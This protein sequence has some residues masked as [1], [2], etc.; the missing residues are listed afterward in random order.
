MARIS[1][2]IDDHCLPTM[3][4]F[5]TYLAELET[6]PARGLSVFQVSS[7]EVQQML[8]ACAQSGIELQHVQASQLALVAGIDG[9]KQLFLIEQDLP[10][11]Q[12]E[13]IAT[14]LIEQIIYPLWF[15]HR[16]ICF[17]SH[18]PQSEYQD[19]QFSPDAVHDSYDAVLSFLLFEQML[20]LLGQRN[21][22]WLSP[23]ALGQPPDQPAQPL[24]HLTARPRPYPYDEDLDPLQKRAKETVRGP[25]RV[26]APAGSGKTKTLTN[27]VIHLLNQ[28][29]PAS[30]ILALAFNRKAAQEMTQRLKAR[31]IRQVEIR[32]FHALGYQILRDALGWR[33][34]GEKEMQRTR[35]LLQAAVKKR[36]QIPPRRD[37]DPLAPF[38]E[39][40][41]YAKS[42]LPDLRDLKVELEEDAVPFEPIFQDFL[43]AQS[44]KKHLTFDDMIYLSA[45][46]LLR[47]DEL[48]H[49]YQ[50]QFHYLL[51][52]EFQDL[53]K[54][55]ILFLTMLALPHNNLFVVG[56]DDQ[57]IYGWRGAEVGHILDFPKRF[58]TA[59]ETVLST[60]YRSTEAIVTHS[61]RL[62]DNNRERVAKNIRPR[63]GAPA[64]LFAVRFGDDLWDQVQAAVNWLQE[65]VQAGALTWDEC[66][67]LY[68]YRAYQYPLALALTQAEIPHS[69]VDLRELFRSPVG[70]DA[71]AYL[72]AVLA[73]AELD[74]DMLQRLLK[75]PNKYFTNRFI[76]AVRSW[77]G[78]REAGRL[79]DLPPWAQERLDDFLDLLQA[80]QGELTQRPIQTAAL[81]YRLDLDVGLYDFYAEKG[82]DKRALDEETDL[83]IWETIYALAANFDRPDAFLAFIKETLAADPAPPPTDEPGITLSTIHQAKGREYPTVVYFNL[84]QGAHGEEP[85]E[86][87]EERRVAY[88]GVTRARRDILI[89][90]QRGRPSLFL[91]EL[92]QDPRYRQKTMGQLIKDRNQLQRSLKKAPDEEK[93]AEL[94]RLEAEINGRRL[95]DPPRLRK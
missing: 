60:N 62:I 18:L 89:T 20:A 91:R 14:Q 43:Q 90:A 9:E 53:N 64:G 49:R 77:S 44:Q 42:S 59:A 21:P 84:S 50:E 33:Y 80:I 32:T 66:A 88:V 24:P 10:R 45:R 25:V 68:R 86:L 56:D 63:Q 23:A 37:S 58:P 8:A 11:S 51:V 13:L 71:V 72:T 93:Q 87:E 65:R 15:A 27:R 34:S 75:R 78:L 79:H 40:L 73:P 76:N 6:S 46:L 94:A 61:R 70:R 52:D 95:L 81:L 12:F 92:V 22:T 85:D 69:Q 2:I 31:G 7:T 28:G 1:A 82:G 54:A 16:P 4:R 5:L 39:M 47:Q 26:L 19:K 83:I 30:Q 55:Q 36:V 41:A 17:L 35:Q 38:L 57:M 74:A 3:N 29:V 48:R 67:I